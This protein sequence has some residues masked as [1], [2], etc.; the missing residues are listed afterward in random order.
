MT[1]PTELPTIEEELT[2]KTLDELENLVNRR[3]LGKITNAEYQ[4]SIDTMFAIC[5]GLVDKGFFDLITKASTE[6]IRDHSFSK[7]RLFRRGN[8][9]TVFNRTK[10]KG[11]FHLSIMNC[12]IFDVKNIT[13]DCDEADTTEATE[14]KIEKLQSKLVTIG[15]KEIY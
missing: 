9:L 8:K 12:A 6:T 2:R 11:S 14:V 13:G 15:F 10:R 5:S 3:E 1:A 7:T 4:A